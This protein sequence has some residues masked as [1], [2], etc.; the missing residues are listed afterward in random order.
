MMLEGLKSLA[1][2]SLRR[3]P[4]RF[5]VRAMEKKAMAAVMARRGCSMVWPMERK[6]LA[7][8]GAEGKDLGG[9]EGRLGGPLATRAGTAEQVVGG[10]ETVVAAEDDGW[11]GFA[12]GLAAG[13]GEDALEQSRWAAR[14]GETSASPSRRLRAGRRPA[15]WRNWGNR[16]YGDR[17]WPD[18]RRRGCRRV[19]RRASPHTARSAAG[20][21]PGWA[22][23]CRIG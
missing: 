23:R 5:R 15:W 8:A 16:P 19:R 21:C 11:F 1:R 20:C 7:E 10:P 2:S 22:L 17:R 14:A 9:G 4:V 6:P 3:T 13:L 18:L 12:G